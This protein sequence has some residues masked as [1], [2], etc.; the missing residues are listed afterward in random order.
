MLHKNSSVAEK[1]RN[2]NMDESLSQKSDVDKTIVLDLTSQ[3]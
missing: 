2:G 1:S 3:Y